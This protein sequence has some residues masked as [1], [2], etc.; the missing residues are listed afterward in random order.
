MIINRANMTVLNTGFSAAFDKGLAGAESQYKRIAMV[1]PSSTRDQTYAWL[2]QLPRLREW[3]GAK[4]IKSLMLHGYSITNRDFELTLEVPRNDIED[5]QYGVFGPLFEEM[6]RSAGEFTDEVV[7]DLLKKGFETVCYDGQ[8]FFDDEHEGAADDGTEIVVSNMQDGEGPAWYLLDTS[9]AIKPVIFQNRKPVRF[10][11]V[12]GDSDDHVFRTG[13]F[14][15]GAEARGNAGFGL[16]QL[17]FASKAP[18]TTDN[19]IAARSAMQGLR[20]EEGRLLGI[21]PDTL[22]V[23]NALEMDARTL[24]MAENKTGG[25]SNI[26]KNTAEILVSPWLG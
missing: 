12:D 3:I 17:A 13:N 11:S 20:G 8:N 7:F 23:P 21:R 22:L 6:G 10:A 9:R 26:L 19:Y 2:G 18:L 16:W 1:A 15:Y 24:L 14:L 25:E 5:D 4:R